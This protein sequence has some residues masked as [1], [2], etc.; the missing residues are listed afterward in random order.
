MDLVEKDGKN[1]AATNEAKQVE[2][3]L[4][5]HRERMAAE[6]SEKVP[7]AAMQANFGKKW[8]MS[9]IAKKKEGK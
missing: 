1:V 4:A 9:K 3:P 5:T 7:A 6:M 2:E 8:D